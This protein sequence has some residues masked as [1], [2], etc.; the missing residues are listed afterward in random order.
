MDFNESV[1]WGGRAWNL[2]N[3]FDK[4]FEN[5]AL[6]WENLFIGRLCLLGSEENDME[7]VRWGDVYFVFLSKMNEWRQVYIVRLVLTFDSS[8]NFFT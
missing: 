3:G 6:Y 4:E 7:R 2:Q 8:L 5:A 1:G